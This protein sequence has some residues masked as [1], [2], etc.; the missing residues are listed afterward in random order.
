MDASS[1]GA[2]LQTRIGPRDAWLTVELH[3]ELDLSTAPA[4]T[5]EIS[6]L[7]EL[8]HPPYIAL[9]LSGLDFCDSSGLNAFIRLWKRINAAGGQLALL[10]PRPG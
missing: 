5:D 4:L 2:K 8:Q 1:G 6:S 7:I 3:G 9:E 10:R